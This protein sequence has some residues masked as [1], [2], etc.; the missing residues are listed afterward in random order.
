MYLCCRITDN[1]RAIPSVAT[2]TASDL[3]CPRSRAIVDNLVV[4]SSNRGKGDARSVN[5]GKGLVQK[6]RART[7]GSMSPVFTNLHCFW[8]SSV[9]INLLPN[10]CDQMMETYHSLLVYCY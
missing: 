10:Q 6:T 4:T 5:V 7:R 8:S 2:L 1:Y 3:A 9:L